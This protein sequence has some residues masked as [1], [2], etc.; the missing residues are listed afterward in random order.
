M[1]P[2]TEGVY[3]FTNTF[4]ELKLSIVSPHTVSKFMPNI[5]HI[6][7]VHLLI[8]LPDSVTHLSYFFY[9]YSPEGFRLGNYKDNIAITSSRCG[10]LECFM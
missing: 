6:Y 8:S 4:L 2:C 1:C 9:K 7:T 3:A 5:K 10:S